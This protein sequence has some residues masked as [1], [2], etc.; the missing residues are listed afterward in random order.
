MKI[1]VLGGGNCQLNL[2]K[3]LKSEGDYIILVDYLENCPAKNYANVHLQMSTFDIPNVVEAAKEYA[4]EAIVTL[5]TDQPV[6]TA[7]TV[8]EELGI[9]F[10]VD[11]D[12]ALKATNKRIMKNIFK[13]NNIPSVNYRLIDDRFNNEDIE[14]LKFPAVLK[15]VDSQGQRGIYKVNNLNEVRQFI[16][17][18]LS[19]SREDKVLLEEYYD[20]DEITV[21]GYLVEGEFYMLSVVDRVTMV[22][23]NHI[24]ICICHNFPSVHLDK[25]NEILELTLKIIESCSF[26]NGPVYFQYLVGKEGIKVNEI[27]MRI[28]GAYEDITIP[29]IADID[30]L[31]LVLDSVKGKAIDKTKLANYDIINNKNCISTQLF[32]C[33][34]GII[35]SITPIDDLKKQP[36]V[37]EVYYDIQAGDEIKTIKNA[38]SRAGYVIVNGE[39]FASMIDNVDNMFNHL[40]V[41]DTDGTNLVIKYKDY[42]EKYKYREEINK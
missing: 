30:I 8:A 21:N 12:Q 3:R 23:D 33:K 36:G 2:I 38:T 27:A 13:E 39:S 37:C 17:S 34:L 1:M 25:Y 14:G 10:Y 15:P 40:K 35:K 26:T 5:G 28:G 7:A 24:G 18:T 9:P 16:D 32:F 29:L 42:K 6:L 22:K 20:N 19:F 11:K 4:I 31:G 41:I